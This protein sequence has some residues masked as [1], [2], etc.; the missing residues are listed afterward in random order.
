MDEGGYSLTGHPTPRTA[1]TLDDDGT[2]PT[3]N[4]GGTNTQQLSPL[5]VKKA[6]QGTI[7]YFATP[8]PQDCITSHHITSKG[9][10]RDANPNIAPHLI[11]SDCIT[12]D[13]QRSPPP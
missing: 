6:Q 13:A 9:G 4:S 7:F 10:R 11:A 12:A 1:E 2:I 3:P 8:D 5:S